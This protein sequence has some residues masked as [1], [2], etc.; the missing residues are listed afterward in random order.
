MVA[1][2]ARAGPA[3]RSR[4]HL[5]AHVGVVHVGVVAVGRVV[6]PAAAEHALRLVALGDEQVHG[7]GDEEQHHELELKRSEYAERAQVKHD[8]K[9]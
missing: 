2:G 4:G 3:V 5:V 6:G 9:E 1:G 8:C 7:H